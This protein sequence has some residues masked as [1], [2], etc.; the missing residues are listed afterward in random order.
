MPAA[1]G[2]SRSTDRPGV[3]SR[4]RSNLASVDVTAERGELYR[5]HGFLVESGIELDAR[6]I[7]PTETTGD[8]DYRIVVGPPREAPHEP[9]KGRLLAEHP[10]EEIGYWVAEDREDPGR[11]TIRYAGI[12]EVEI[13]R[14]RRRITVHRAPAGSPGMM[15]IMVGGSAL[16]HAIAADGHLV[17]HASAVEVNGGAVAIVG[18]SGA[19]KSTLTALLCANGA[20][21]IADDTL[22][23]AVT[24]QGVTCFPGGLSVRLRPAAASLAKELDGKSHETADGRTAVFPPETARDPI[25][26]RAAFIPVP[27]SRVPA[28]DVRRLG[29][30]DGLVEL[31]RNPRLG[32]WLDPRPIAGLFD[33]TAEVAGLTPVLQVTIPWGPPFPPGLARELLREIGSE[34]AHGASA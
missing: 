26:L 23:C 10:L 18:P 21:L 34:P 6:T 33:L 17:L 2:H 25:E 32:F 9:P 22:R 7:A 15:S 20:R 12:G 4:L 8:P 31:L 19:G 16:A 27:S 30:M 13:D 24:K 1:P 11:W 29:G 14:R 28:L 5:I 3:R